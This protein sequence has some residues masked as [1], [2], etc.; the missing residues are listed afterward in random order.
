MNRRYFLNLIGVG[1][2]A[3]LVK[4]LLPV[5]KASDKCPL[6]DGYAERTFRLK[7]GGAAIIVYCESNE[8]M[9]RVSGPVAR[10]HFHAA[11]RNGAVSQDCYL[12]EK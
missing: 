7:K 10:A 12:G 1:S 11:K 2:A 5:A 4:P 8:E 6:D 9:E 3:L